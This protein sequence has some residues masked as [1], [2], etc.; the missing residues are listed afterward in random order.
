MH[1]NNAGYTLIEVLVVIAIVGILASIA[2][3]TLFGFVTR[4]TMRS[5]S[6]DFSS[7]LQR[8]RMEAVN[9][10]MCAT[11]CMTT[12]ASNSAPTCVTSGDDWGRGWIVFLNPTCDSPSAV[13]TPVPGNIVLVRETSGARYSLENTNSGTRRITFSARGNPRLNQAGGFNLI[14]TEA[15]A[16]DEAINRTICLDQVGRVRVIESLGACS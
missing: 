7:G 5:I 3:P 2:A 13:N 16:S 6:S 14:D 12:T 8:T 4:S 10:N 11:M 1:H 15:P 9:R